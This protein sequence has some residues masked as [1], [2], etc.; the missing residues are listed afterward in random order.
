MTKF[1]AS[2][3]KHSVKKK[4]MMLRNAKESDQRGLQRKFFVHQANYLT[5]SSRSA[6]CKLKRY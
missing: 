1:A 2:F 4:R 5:N 6:T 3:L